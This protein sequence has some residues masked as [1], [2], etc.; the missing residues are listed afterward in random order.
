MRK[1][2][3]RLLLLFVAF[4]PSKLKVWLLNKMGHNIHPTAYIGMSYLDV[5]SITLE[6]DTYIGFGNAFR[7]LANLT[8]AQGSRI[9]RWNHFTSN[10]SPE[11]ELRLNN[12][13][14]IS[15][16]HY[17][18]V[19]N[20]VEIGQNTIIAGHRSTFFTH[21]KGIH[22][23]DYSKP[24]K[25][26]EWCYI[27]S[28]TCITPGTALGDHCFVGMGCVLSGNKSDWKYALVVGNP[29]F[30][31]MEIPIDCEYFQQPYIQHAHLK[32][33]HESAN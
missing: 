26:G 7:N 21:S 5:K 12:Y 1:Q 32:N 10:N 20:L 30:V 2:L 23:I 22:T 16:R 4:L 24:I 17:F 8:M 19:C 18:D 31:K 11:A 33:T 13:A 6:R 3:K 9:N 29:A 28:N 25:I 27:G 14:S 15:L